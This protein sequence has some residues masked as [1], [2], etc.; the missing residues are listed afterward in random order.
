MPG[1][2][3]DGFGE[4]GRPWAEVGLPAERYWTGTEFSDP[5]TTWIVRDRE[6]K[7]ILAVSPQSGLGRVVCIPK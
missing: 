6:G 3:I 1:T 4:A 5:A 7:V 2:R